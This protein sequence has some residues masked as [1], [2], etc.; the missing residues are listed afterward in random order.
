MASSFN[1]AY[2]PAST[3]RAFSLIEVVL[4]VAVT[5]FCLVSVVSLFPVG[6]NS[7]VGSRNQT[8]AAYLAKEIVSDIRSSSITNATLLYWDTTNAELGSLP[9]PG[10]NPD[11]TV[12]QPLYLACDTTNN[13]VST[14][15]AAQYAS[16]MNQPNIN[17]LVQLSVSS[18]A[19]PNLFQVSIEV[20]APAQAALVA[21]ARY[22][23]QT[24]IRE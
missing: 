5:S 9:L 10:G 15:T 19:L 4:A 21:R 18:T 6:L 13:I 12:N 20:S 8:R 2:G 7:A 14:A 11:L 3:A 1:R 23:F 22:G 17:S 24:M 16:G